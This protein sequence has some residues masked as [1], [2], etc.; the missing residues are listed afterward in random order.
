MTLDIYCDLT[1][2]GKLAELLRQGVAPHRLTWGTRSEG[3]GGGRVHAAL[4]ESD[5]AFGQPEVSSVLESPR[6]RW[7]HISSAG[8]T[9]YDTPE[10]RAAA[11]NKPLMLTNSS[12]VYAE[13]CAEHVF[14]FMLAQAR[15]LPESL[16]AGANRNLELSQPLRDTCTLLRHQRVVILGFGSIARHLVELL[17]PFRMEITAFRR[18]RVGD[19]G[20]PIVTRE[21]LDAALSQA[22]HVVNLLPASP[23]SERLVSGPQFAAMKK[24][25]VFYNI[26]RGVTVNQDD[27]ATALRTKNLG[28]AWLDVTDPEPL[29]AGHPLLS[30]PNCHITP[31]TA[32]GQQNEAEM[33]IRHFLENFGRFVE[34][35]EMQD[36]IF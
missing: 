35:R 28:A 15:R 32:G 10:F 31:H 25:A 17:R 14:A 23:G 7:V 21:G 29:P 9:R 30:A 36:R 4:A 12:S 27:L 1:V 34:Q 16:L 6:L 26:G 24:G 13:A 3:Q 11:K 33:L 18:K 8:Y 20:V 22:D 2:E 5:I 19:E